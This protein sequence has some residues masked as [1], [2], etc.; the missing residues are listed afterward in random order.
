MA[1][2]SKRASKASKSGTSMTQRSGKGGNWHV[3]RGKDMGSVTRDA[4]RQVIKN[5]GDA[6]EKL[7]EH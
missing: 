2:N 4:T 6:L 3:P 7:K 1:Q 5:Y